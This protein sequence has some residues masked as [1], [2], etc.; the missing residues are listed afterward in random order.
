MGKK[1][2]TGISDKRLKNRRFRKT[3]ELILKIV[4]R[5]GFLV[6]TRDVANKAGVARSTIYRH[7]QTLKRVLQDYQK[8]MVKK[9]RIWIKSKSNEKM[10][11]KMLYERMIVFIVQNQFVFEMLVKHGGT[12]VLKE[13]IMAL[14]PKIVDLVRLPKNHQ[15]VFLVYT[16]E[17]VGLIEAWV[18]DGCDDAK[19][20]SLIT[21]A[22]YLTETMRTRLKGL[23][24]N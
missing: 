2:A 3:E 15:K 11:P 7:H 12:G 9:F 17:I 19:I 24:D 6:S 18:V 8:F 20:K 16:N 14:E 13:M 4:F 23:L 10:T 5:E 22:V 1:Y 21:D